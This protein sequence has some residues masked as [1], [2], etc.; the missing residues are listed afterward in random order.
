MLLGLLTFT[1]FTGQLIDPLLGFIGLTDTEYRPGFSWSAFRSIKPGDSKD[2][3][4]AE[5]G[6]PVSEFPDYWFTL[7]FPT[8]PFDVD[9]HFDN[10]GRLIRVEP[11]FGHEDFLETVK[12]LKTEKDVLGR[13]GEPNSRKETT[14]EQAWI[15]TYSH[16]SKNFWACVVFIDRNTNKVTRTISE[17]HFQ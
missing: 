13:F 8:I 4:L 12:N 2:L 16:D 10:D 17:L 6:L 11:S 1:P 5:L 3:V 9:Y 15:Y 14:P 7:R